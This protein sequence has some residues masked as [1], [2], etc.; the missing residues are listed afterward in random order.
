MTRIRRHYEVA[1]VSSGSQTVPDQ[2]E[3]GFVAEAFSALE[4]VSTGPLR[5][6]AIGTAPI[7]IGAW[8]TRRSPDVAVLNPST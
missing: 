5:E 4:L 6:C 7:R 2:V 1:R 3:D 8:I